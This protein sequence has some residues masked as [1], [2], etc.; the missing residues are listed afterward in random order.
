MSGM[1]DWMHMTHDEI[2]QAVQRGP[3]GG[4]GMLAEDAWRDVREII[5]AAEQRTHAAIA[6][7]GAEW[8]GGGADGARAALSTLNGW[9]LGAVDDAWNTTRALTEQGFNAESF[10]YAVPAPHAHELFAAQ[11]EAQADPNS[12][13]AAERAFRAE[14][15]AQ[16]PIVQEMGER[17]K[18][19]LREYVNNSYANLAAMS[20]WSVPPVVTVETSPVSPAGGTGPGAAG[21]GAAGGTGGGGSN[22]PT[23]GVGTH[24]GPAGGPVAAGITPVAHVPVGSGGGVGGGSVPTGSPPGA[25]PTVPGG[26]GGG[27]AAVPAAGAP[28]IGAGSPG[29]GGGPERVGTGGAPVALAPGAGGR[30]SRPVPDPRAGSAG[31]HGVRPVVPR[32]PAPVAPSP[33]WRDL[34][35]GGAA[36]SPPGARPLSGPIGGR[37]GGAG[38]GPGAWGGGGGAGPAHPVSPRGDAG[39]RLSAVAAQTAETGRGGPAGGQHGLYPPMAGGGSGGQGQERRRAPFLVD[40]SGVFDV[41]VACTEPVIG[42]EPSTGPPREA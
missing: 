6:A 14:S 23:A 13:Y 31:G 1:S 8:E 21:F 29:G 40:D 3:G 28:R 16:H 34:V 10:R 26:R 9:V 35:A 37:P 36:G 15:T 22:G 41:P 17:A 39:P 2:Y 20:Y 32:A 42:G 4:A 38:G 19:R 30:G 33:T 24:G 11:S 25:V 5:V 18:D 12:H 27:P 7:S